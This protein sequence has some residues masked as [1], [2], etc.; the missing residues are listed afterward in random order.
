MLAEI[1][2]PNMIIALNKIDTL[3]IETRAAEIDKKSKALLKILASTRFANATI[4]PISAGANEN[5]DG[6]K[7]T[8]I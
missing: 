2:A 6:L 7:E 1:L 8:I 5:I 3:P 4:V